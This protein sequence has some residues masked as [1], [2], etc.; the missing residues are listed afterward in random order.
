MNRFV[1][2]ISTI[3]VRKTT[4]NARVRQVGGA[5]VSYMFILSPLGI[6]KFWT[7]LAKAVLHRINLGHA[8]VTS[9]EMRSQKGS[10]TGLNLRKKSPRYVLLQNTCI[11]F[12]V[13]VLKEGW[14]KCFQSHF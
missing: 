13:P 1:N 10:R 2:D 3:F 7:N 4:K 14:Q 9:V 5:L 6:T 8:G 11:Q 12:N